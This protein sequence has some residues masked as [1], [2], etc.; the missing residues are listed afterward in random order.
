MRAALIIFNISYPN[1]IKGNTCFFP[2][3]FVNLQTFFIK[4]VLFRE[5]NVEE[6]SI[7]L[8]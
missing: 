7:S 2:F 8:S 4:S 1:I 3:K 5:E 6:G